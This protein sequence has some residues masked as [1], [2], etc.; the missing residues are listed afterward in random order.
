VAARRLGVIGTAAETGRFAAASDPTQDV[1][2]VPAF[3][4]LGAPWWDAE[5]RGAIFGLT[6]NTGP[7]NSPARRWNPSLPDARPARRDAARLAGPTHRDGAARR[8][9]HG[10]ERLDDA[11]PR[12]RPR[13]AGRPPEVLETTAL[14]A[15][16]LAGSRAGVWPKAKQFSKA[17]A[18][19]R[20]FKPVMEPSLRNAKLKGWH[21]AVR[22]TL[23][24]K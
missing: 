6:R 22:R 19:D 15:A 5:A 10:G 16:W 8:R 17:W 3:V 21:D 12:R 24:P 14:G 9:R 23:T 1:Y 11:A 2:L 7:A 13:R 4:G 20:Q 18:L